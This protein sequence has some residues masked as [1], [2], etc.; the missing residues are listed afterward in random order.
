MDKKVCIMGLGYIGLP[1]AAFFATAGYQVI[2]VDVSPRVIEGINNH[3]I[4]VDEPG[5]AEVVKKAVEEG[6]LTARELPELADVFII[7]VPTPLKNG[8]KG[9]MSSV[10]DAAFTLLPYL[11]PGNLVILESTVGPGT[12]EDLLCPILAESGLSIGEELMVAF[13]PERVLPG[14]IMEEMVFNNR[15]VGGINRESA[16][17]AETLYQSFVKGEIFLTEAATAEAVK[18]MENTFRDVNIALANELARISSKLGINVWEAIELANKHP[19]VNIH[20]PGPG[21]G[22]HC[23]AVD[24][25][26]IVEKSPQEARLI[27]L[28]RRINDEMPE[29]VADLICEGLKGLK[30]PKAA[31]LGMA[32]KGGVQDTR[33]SPSIKVAEIL[34]Q[35]GIATGI[36]DPLVERE[37]LAAYGLILNNLEEALKGADLLVVLTDHPDFKLLKPE[38]LVFLVRNKLVLD[39]RNILDKYQWQEA[40]FT[41]YKIGE[42]KISPSWHPHSSTL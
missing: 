21:V 10:E 41:V 13:C 2:G 38:E 8:C 29:F 16:L 5:L 37:D 27:E 26:F 25:W 7:A 24:P 42:G 18:L 19:R 30:D 20:Q 34:Q 33:E 22:G 1:T 12:T 15:I 35:R 28:S 40:G 36:Y 39:T 3:R 32:Y 17:R 23:I 6:K 9:D 31:L 11:R 14:K 4:H